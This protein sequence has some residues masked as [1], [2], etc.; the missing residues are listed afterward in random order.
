MKELEKL[1]QEQNEWKLKVETRDAVI[2]RQR[3][4]IHDME[5]NMANMSDALK[6]QKNQTQIFRAK[7]RKLED[8]LA[9]MNK[10]FEDLYEIHGTSSDDTV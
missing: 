2:A 10:Q 8:E 5:S 1:K 4:Q 7:S 6:Y 3:L 9:L